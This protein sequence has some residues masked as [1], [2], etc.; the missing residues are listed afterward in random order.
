MLGLAVHIGAALYKKCKSHPR[1][2]VDASDLLYNKSRVRGLKSHQR[3]LVD[4]S[5]PLYNKSRVRGLKSHQRELVDASD[6]L[7][8]KSRVRGFNP[9]NGSWW[10]V[11][12]LS[13]QNH[14]CT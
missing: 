12:I 3:E 10:M 1:Q 2:W 6:P 14:F 13:T 9:T 8:N 5:D 7:Y 4:G 11:Q